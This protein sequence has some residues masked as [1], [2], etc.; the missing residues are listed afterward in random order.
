MLRTFDV[1]LILVMMAT[2]T[3]T[4]SIKHRA[5]LKLDDVRRLETEIKLEKDTIELL[6]AD[7]ALLTQPNRLE[8][9]I[10]VYDGELQLVPTD[11]EQ[12]AQ[13]VELPMLRADLPPPDVTADKDGKSKAVPGNAAQDKIA[14]ASKDPVGALVEADSGEAGDDAET[15][16]ISTGSV[17]P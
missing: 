2:A 1:I 6:R 12:L 13:P 3:I 7:W 5:E 15:D 9:L 8:R 4:Y 11:P 10:K 16:G 14:A 17:E